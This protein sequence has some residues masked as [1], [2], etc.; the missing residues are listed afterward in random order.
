MTRYPKCPECGQICGHFFGC[1]E[2]PDEPDEEVP[3]PTS[4]REDDFAP[5]LSLCGRED[6]AT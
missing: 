6:G 2:T 1:P 4:Q 5:D 3:E